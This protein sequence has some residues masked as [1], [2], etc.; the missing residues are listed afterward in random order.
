M[1][2]FMILFSSLL[3]MVS[4]SSRNKEEKV[5]HEVASLAES[6]MH[7]SSMPRIKGKVGFEDMKDEIKV[8]T[9]ISGLKPNAKLGFHI[10]ENSICEGPE[11]KSAGDHL[12]PYAEKHSGPHAHASH[13]GDMGNLETNKSGEAKM[14]VFIPK[15]QRDDMN[16]L[17]GKAVI[18]HEKVDDLRSQPAGNS[19]KR[20]ACGLIR[21]IEI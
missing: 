13:L 18:I 16:L 20:I 9:E 2:N 5:T 7:S 6:Q 8:T 11:Y 19:G 4:C 1:K 15:E 14:V 10:H 17:L 3:V 12:N 21:P